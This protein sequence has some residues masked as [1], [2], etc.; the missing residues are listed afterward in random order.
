M[1]KNELYEVVRDAEIE[2]FDAWQKS[3]HTNN[4]H[5]A[6]LVLHFLS[7]ALRRAVKR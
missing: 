7:N 4:F 3:T 5:T 6:Y 2:A 1:T